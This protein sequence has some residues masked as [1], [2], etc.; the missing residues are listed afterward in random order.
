MPRPLYE[1]ESNGPEVE[2][3]DG[4]ASEVDISSKL[5]D[6]SRYNRNNNS[7]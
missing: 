6:S 7:I 2:G 1:Y 5:S 4:E 3:E